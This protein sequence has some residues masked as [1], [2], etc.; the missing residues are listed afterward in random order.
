[1]QGLSG[2]SHLAMLDQVGHHGGGDRLPAN[3]LAL[4]PEQD[5]AL[6]RVQAGRAR[7]SAPPRRPVRVRHTGGMR[8]PGNGG[9]TAAEQDSREQIR[10]AAAAELI[11][12]GASDRKMTRHFRVSANR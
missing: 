5:Q 10:L 4:L 1:M 11:G 3:G 8:Y 6:I 2:G 7:A 9:L 12:A